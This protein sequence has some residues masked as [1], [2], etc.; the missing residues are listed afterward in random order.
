MKPIEIAR[1][2]YAAFDAHD[3]AK[4]RALM[5]D[6]FRFEG[7][8]M[9]TSSPEELFQ[10]MKAFQCEFT[11]RL[12]HMVESGNT[13]ATL[14]DSEFSKPFQATIRMSEWLTIDNGKIKSAVL[15]YD[16]KKMPMPTS[17]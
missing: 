17:A 13:V 16:T 3:F 11:N 2:Y 7:P 6:D 12:K 5:A 1:N 8:M 10:A 15:V 9:S 4:A 14:F